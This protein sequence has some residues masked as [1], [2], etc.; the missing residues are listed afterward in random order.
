ML[1]YPKL[2]SPRVTKKVY[3]VYFAPV[4]VLKTRR[5]W[6]NTQQEVPARPDGMLVGGVVTPRKKHRS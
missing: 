5:E 4:L 2:T 1:A 3:F 6:S